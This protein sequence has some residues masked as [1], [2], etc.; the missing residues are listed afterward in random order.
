MEFAGVIPEDAPDPRLAADARVRAVPFP[1][2][3]LTPQPALSRLPI[4]GSAESGIGTALEEWSMI[5]GYTFWRHPENRDDPRNEREL[6]E[7]A[8]RSI[9]DEPP[10][11]RPAWLIEMAQVFRYPMLQDAVRTTR[12]GSERVDA[13]VSNQLV[14]HANHVLRNS[15]REQLGLPVRIGPNFGGEVSHS[16]VAPASLV[17]DGERRSAL[18]IDTDPF[19]YAV[20]V[21]VAERVI[22]TVVVDREV[23]P[24]LDLAVCRLGD[25]T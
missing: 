23:L 7:R 4:P 6:D 13:T 1:V 22:C 21:D 15:F 5:F 20:G 3:E 9:Q 17:V 2:M 19:V 18:H 16:A 11:G 8:R 14:H 10:W 12:Y 24:F 25:L